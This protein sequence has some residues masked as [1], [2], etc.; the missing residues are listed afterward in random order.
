MKIAI[1]HRPGS[2]SDRWIEYCKQQ[3]VDYQ[4]VNAYDNDIVEQVNG[5]DAFMW[6]HHQARFADTM[7]ARQLLYSLETRGVCCFPNF[8]TTWHFDDKV[9]QKYLLEAVGAPLV[10]S[11][12]FYSKESA[13]DWI[14]HTTYP[15][16]FK[17]RGG[18]G[19][20][21][22][23]LVHNVKEARAIVNKSFGNGFAQ[24]RFRT[25]LSE[26]LRKHREGKMTSGEVVRSIG[27]YFLKPSDY[28]KLSTPERGYV[29]FQ[30]FIPNNSF[31]IRVC[32]VDNKAFALK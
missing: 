28:H 5:C 11:Y 23:L 29:Y 21:N 16:V 7:F 25:L 3:G 4:I 1:H 20:V 27:A 9:G 18:A 10:P 6:H 17:L 31:D 14:E 32:V 30:E 22:V 8:H 24:M 26:D 15:K 13:L 19:A 12:V 2:F